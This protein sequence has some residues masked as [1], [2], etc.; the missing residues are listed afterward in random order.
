MTHTIGQLRASILTAHNAKTDEV[1][2]AASIV[3]GPEG[4]VFD[5]YPIAATETATRQLLAR[6]GIPYD[7]FTTRMNTHERIAVF[8]R[9][10]T[11]TGNA[12]RMLRF[13]GDTL[14]GVVSERYKVIDNIE[15]LDVIESAQD[16]GFGLKPVKW[17][18]DHDHTRVVLVPDGA[19]V[20]ELTPSV[21]IT[22]SETGLGCL[23][24]WAGVYRW[25]CTNGLMVPI[26]DITKNRW[27]HMGSSDVV[28]PD[29]GLVFNRSHEFTDRLYYAKAEPLDDTARDRIF[30]L[31]EGRFGKKTA[32]KVQEV[33]AAE[34]SGAPTMFHA[35]NAITRTAQS[36]A[37]V[38]QSEIELFASSLLA[39]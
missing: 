21:T 29:M 11:E 1:R 39:A 8:N 9:L 36:Y 38:R 12:R 13:S 37:P 14:Y 28:L 2:T 34:Y 22:N 7:F 5:G 23:S 17:T 35:V 18:L 10:N 26:G 30:T 16:S 15:I 19:N 27:M 31:V 3:Y 33:A 6:V 25:V 32:G 24:M 20:G 4:F